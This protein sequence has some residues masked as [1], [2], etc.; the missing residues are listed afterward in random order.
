MS[1]HTEGR[2]TIRARACFVMPLLVLALAPASGSTRVL[3]AAAQRD[4]SCAW[5]AVGTGA[6]PR[7]IVGVSALPS[8]DVWFVGPEP[9][10]QNPRAPTISHWDGRRL[11]TVF[12]I[13]RRGQAVDF[14]LGDVHALAPDDVWAVG[15][16]EGEPLILHWDGRR[17]QRMRV[18]TGGTLYALVALSRNDVWAVGSAGNVNP[19]VLHWNGRNW[20]A[21]RLRRQGALYA[22][23]ASGRSDVWALGDDNALGGQITLVDALA[24]RWQGRRWTGVPTPTPDD[25]DR[26][27]EATD[28]FMSVHAVS[29]N[30]AWAIHSGAASS[31]VQRWDGRMWRIAMRF[32][33]R[34]LQAVARLTPR[35]VWAVGGESHPLV[36]HWDGREWADATPSRLRARRGS[37]E[38]ISA[39]SARDIWAAGPRMLAR[40]SC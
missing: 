4:P 26:G 20:D 31:D 40:Y 35:D 22:V 12:P 17:W 13:G 6:L 23:D 28:F 2:R 25:I 19:L 7:E 30:E 38:D 18:A 32:R 21:N 27:Y 36:M 39:V 1:V 24:L 33:Y 37:F 16:S 10:T 8:G 15:G 5:R 29:E 34:Y 9:Y 14:W 11:A 3:E